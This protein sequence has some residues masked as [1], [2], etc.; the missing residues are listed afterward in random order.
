MSKLAPPGL[1]A[2]AALPI[3][4]GALCAELR[5]G[6]AGAAHLASWLPACW[7]APERFE[8]SLYAYAWNRRPEPIRT[9]PE[10]GVDLYADCITTK[11]GAGRA[12]LVLLQDG[13]PREISYEWL[14]ERCS[15]LASAWSSAGVS[16]GASIAIVLPVGSEY[17]VALLTG[18]RLGLVITTIAPLG[19]S[20]VRNRLARVAPDH[21]VSTELYAALLPP[22]APA[23]LSPR[24]SGGD[25]TRSS[26]HAYAGHEPVLRLLSP[27]G[28]ADAPPYELQ[29]G[30]LHLSL[31][32]DAALV[33]GLQAG[34]RIAAPGFDPMQWQ[35]LGL[36]CALL[37]GA[38]WVELERADLART[39]LLMQRLGLSVLGIDCDLRELCLARGP[40]FCHGL[41]SW[42]RSLSDVYDYVRWQQLEQRLIAREVLGFTVLF[43]AAS[44]G[45]HLFSPP[46]LRSEPACL[47]PAPGRRFVIAQPGADLLPSIHQTGVYVPL[48]QDEPDPSLPSMV[49]A[50]LALGWTM[51]GSID[52]GPQARALPLLEIARSARR[53]PRVREACV[54]ITPGRFTNDGHSVLL[55]F[56]ADPEPSG[57][58]TVPSAEVTRMVAQDLGALN[59]PERVDSFMLHPRFKD[60]QL[61]GKWCTSQYL[62]GALTRKARIPL[63]A[64]LARLAWIFEPN[65]ASQ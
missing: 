40:E 45:A 26:S 36:L 47:W 13:Q 14:H 10:L 63:F 43:N 32:R 20:F 61:D 44:G 18:L 58:T 30:E 22:G 11:L 50:K 21:V 42:F 48:R 49:I 12:A 34:D 56:V 23:P 3:D 1:S 35:P 64:T 54:V 41:R 39:P 19:P 17:A 6:R 24:A 59:A 29:A 28:P 16:A 7:Q 52:P 62:S 25:T 46:S 31:L 38:T 15:A 9:R 4:I 57:S 55:A 51:G 8:R 27:F 2:H 65:T 37:A 33:L 53:H 5:T 60:G